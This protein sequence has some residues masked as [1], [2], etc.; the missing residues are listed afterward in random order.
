MNND[1]T[2]V[3]TKY[4]GREQVCERCGA[5]PEVLYIVTGHNRLSLCTCGNVK[6]IEDDWYS[7]C[8]AEM[9]L[10]DCRTNK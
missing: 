4:D 7:N 3:N 2:S 9:C 10:E 5:V 6:S 8:Y 1:K